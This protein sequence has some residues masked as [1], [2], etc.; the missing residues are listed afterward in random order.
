VASAAGVISLLTRPYG[1]FKWLFEETVLTGTPRPR[2]LF[3]GRKRRYRAISKAGSVEVPVLEVGQLN[4]AELVHLVGRD[5]PDRADIDDLGYDLAYELSNT[6]GLGLRNLWE[7]AKSEFR[8]L[9][10]TDDPKYDDLRERARGISSKHTDT[11]VASLA[12]GLGAMIGVS[13]MILAP[14]VGL[15]LLAASRLGTETYCRVSAA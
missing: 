2:S 3:T 10:C 14:L 6:Q 13:A 1:G 8:L 4:E 9:I 15:L 7:A 11:L 12:A 5:V